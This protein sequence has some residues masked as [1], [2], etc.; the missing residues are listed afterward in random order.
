MILILI[1]LYTCFIYIESLAILA[2][3]A[4]QIS[5][6]RAMGYTMHNAIL[7]LNRFLGFMIGPLVGYLIEIGYDKHK[8][9]YVAM[10][11]SILGG[12]ATLLNAL[13]SKYSLER[14][15]DILNKIKKDGYKVL[16]FFSCITQSSRNKL[17]DMQKIQL[18]MADFNLTFSV[19]ITTSLYYGVSFYL[20]LIAYSNLNYRGT[21]LQMTGVVT[22]VGSL[23]LNFY[24]FPKLTEF[25]NKGNAL[26]GYGSIYLGKIVGLI[27]I[28][29]A[30][31]LIAYKL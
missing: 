5:H 1:F 30:F 14:F 27:I 23:L 26:N 17:D 28:Q 29:P 10:F 4:G 18:K 25:E 21:I 24:T 6:E 11:C 3:Y 7:A 2:R 13:Y 22:G 16:S 31:V 19:A 9:F 12:F 15:I 20:G 8:L